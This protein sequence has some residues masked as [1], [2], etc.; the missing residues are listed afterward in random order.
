[1]LPQ[2]KKQRTHAPGSDQPTDIEANY[3]NHHSTRTVAAQTKIILPV[4]E[5]MLQMK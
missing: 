3:I 2:K 5:T 4:G 1:M